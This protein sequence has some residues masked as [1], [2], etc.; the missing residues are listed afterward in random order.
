MLCSRYQTRPA[1]ST[2]QSSN[3]FSLRRGEAPRV[4]GRT[5]TSLP[6]KRTRHH[7]TTP[8]PHTRERCAGSSKP[9]YYKGRSIVGMQSYKTVYKR[10][11]TVVVVAF[12]VV[13]AA[14]NGGVGDRRSCERAVVSSSASDQYPS[15]QRTSIL[16]QYPNQRIF[17]ALRRRRR[18]CV[19]SLYLLYS[20]CL[21]EQRTR[22]CS[23]RARITR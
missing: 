7:L 9:S 5:T 19:M 12:V 18:Y 21:C 3:P 6:D 13:V 23:S 10:V 20:I 8:T 15:R 14:S 2:M 1:Q 11:V 22:A 16:Y 4:V 17:A